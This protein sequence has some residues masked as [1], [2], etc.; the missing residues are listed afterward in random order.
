MIS[1]YICPWKLKRP[2]I[3]IQEET[4][5]KLNQDTGSPLPSSLYWYLFVALVCISLMTNVIEHPFMCLLA[6][7]LHIFF[8]EVSIQIFAHILSACVFSYWVVGVF[9]FIYTFWIQVLCL[10]YMC[11]KYF[12]TVTCLFVF[13]IMPFKRALKKKRCNSIYPVFL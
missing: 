1:A 3:K 8:S 13:L 6:Q 12:L 10:I 7:D 4:L 11:C 5:Q 9:F 2:A